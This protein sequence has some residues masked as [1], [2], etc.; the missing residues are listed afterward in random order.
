MIVNI[1]NYCDE[2]DMDLS[3]ENILSMY[4]QIATVTKDKNYTSTLYPLIPLIANEF[5]NQHKKNLEIFKALCQIQ[6][7]WNIT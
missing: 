7:E 1:T 5:L 3:T 4:N 2:G 6:L